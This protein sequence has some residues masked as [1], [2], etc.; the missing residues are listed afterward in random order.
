M[1]KNIYFVQV[2]D[3]YGD[4]QKTT[5]FPYATGCIQAFC[6]QNDII[7]EN[8]EFKKI[9]YSRKLI[10]DV[11]KELDNPFMVLFSCSVWNMEYNKALAKAVK[12]AYLN[13]Y[14]VFGGHNI[15]PDGSILEKYPYVDF[16]THR[17]GEEPTEGLLVNLATNKSLSQVANI[18]YRD[19]DGNV[20][21]TKYEPQTGENYPSPY[22]TGVFE[23]IMKDDIKF[24]GLFETN[25][26]CPNSC[27]FCDWSSLKSK[28]RLFP[29]ERVIS[30]IDWF[31]AHKIE[32]IFCAD[33]NF[34]LFDR[35]AEIADYLVE[36]KEKYGY[37]KI[38]K[39][40]FTKNRFNFVFDVST[41][42]FRS[43]LDKAKTISFQSLSDDVLKN[44]G[45]KNISTDKYRELIK[46]YNELNIATFSELI[47]GLPGETYQS[48]CHGVCDLIESGQH[49]SINIYPCELLPNAEMGQK[50]YQEKFGIKSTRVP[51]SLIHS[52][53]SKS[54]DDI[55][56]YSEYITSTSSMNSKEWARALL[57]SSY[58]QALHN[59]G[60]LRAVAIYLR[61]EFNI[62]YDEFYNTL[63]KYSETCAN[64]VLN[65]VYSRINGL[66]N[67]IIDGKN[68]MVDTCDG[69][70]EM[71][72]SFDELTFFEFYKELQ[73]FYKEVKEFVLSTYS[74]DKIIDDLFEYQYNIIKKIGK[75]DI[76]I[77]SNYN[78]YSYYCKIYR[79]DYEKLNK[80]RMRLFVHDNM[81]VETFS[82]LAR[83][84][85]WY[86][87]NRR[88]SD[89][90]SNN[91][92]VKESAF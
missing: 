61:H 46:K 74:Q 87:R 30:E 49:Y 33:G 45:R 16:L 8:Y 10:K 17:F 90:T 66:C 28:V 88:A 65:K 91:Y 21:T 85:V 14:I 86:G 37:P 35:D 78:F 22:L 31:A 71:W 67:G 58:I 41:K 73:A 82:D 3:I 13:C 15:S 47:L 27:S 51:F 1:K 25:R 48:F 54:E 52:N 39:A 7:V 4:E 84:V 9:I 69:L 62:S 42:F 72:W 18:S 81:P 75:T 63:I 38:F 83:E 6:M 79:G 11:I 76:F 53:R 68:G 36:C 34:C 24:S 40:L 89:Y 70:G 43:G 29:M 26:G 50:A 77:E 60:L 32:Y 55:I 23:D 59:L 20:L 5:Y 2:N 44:V 12:K 92:I 80:E 57:F 19:I 56:E 64:S